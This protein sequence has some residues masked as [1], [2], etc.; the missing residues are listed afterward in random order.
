MSNQAMA[1]PDFKLDAVEDSA[2][3]A[4]RAIGPLTSEARSV[5]KLTTR[6]KND[7]AVMQKYSDLQHVQLTKIQYQL[8]NAITDDKLYEASL[9][10]IVAA[11]K[12]L[13]DKELVSQG[14]PTEIHGLVGYLTLLETEEITGVRQTIPG[15]ASTV[16]DAGEEEEGQIEELPCL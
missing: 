1:M 3:V 14:R 13:K 9:R 7:E 11:F 8:L 2:S 15:V 6:L 16:I 4:R 5:E 12:I 10:D